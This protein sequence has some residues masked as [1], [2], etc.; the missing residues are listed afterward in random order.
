MRMSLRFVGVTA[1]VLAAAV[2]LRPVPIAAQRPGA[3]KPANPG[4][5]TIYLSTYKGV[6]QVL[7]EATEKITAEIPTK[8]GI[9]GDVTFSDDRSRLYIQDVSY[10][11]VEIIDRVKRTTIDNFTLTEDKAKVRIWSL[12]PDPHDKYLILVIK[13]YTLLNDRWEIC[14]LYTSPSPRDS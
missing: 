8:S 9:P 7:D 12:Q 13:K 5:G 6:I 4:G 10:E 3:A 11:K 14:L 1:A 2:L